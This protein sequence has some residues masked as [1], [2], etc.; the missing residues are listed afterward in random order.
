M[1]A[2]GSVIFEIPFKLPTALDHSRDFARKRQL[3]EANTAQLKLSDKAARP[4]TALAAAVVP[5]GKF[6]FLCFFRNG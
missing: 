1:S 6:L 3:P 2:I 5:H 4:T